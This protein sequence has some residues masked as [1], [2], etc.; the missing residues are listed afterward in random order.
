M[1]A[2]NDVQVWL[3]LS[4]F[5]ILCNFSKHG[6]KTMTL[7]RIWREVDNHDRCPD[8]MGKIEDLNVHV[9]RSHIQTS[10]WFS[11]LNPGVPNYWLC[12]R[13][14]VTVRTVTWL[15]TILYFYFQ[16]F[17]KIKKQHVKR[18]REQV[19]WFF[20]LF[21][22]LLSAEHL[23]GGRNEVIRAWGRGEEWGVWTPGRCRRRR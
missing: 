8:Q 23:G 5:R 7:G 3:R 6:Q 12:Y 1:S 11:Q 15:R 18:W 13:P 21:A 4:T 2:H 16:F 22:L 20:A 10:S 17:F 9:P 19:S 14:S